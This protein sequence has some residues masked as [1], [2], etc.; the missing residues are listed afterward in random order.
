MEVYE[1]TIGYQCSRKP[2]MTITAVEKL[3][4]FCFV[5]LTMSFAHDYTEPIHS[6][7]SNPIGDEDFGFCL[8]S[9]LKTKYARQHKHFS[10]LLLQIPLTGFCKISTR[11]LLAY[12]SAII[13]HK[14]TFV[15]KEI[16]ADNS[17]LYLR[18]QVPFLHL[19]RQF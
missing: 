19:V 10:S 6:P 9:L 17:K 8:W 7:L 18:E 4:A 11:A 16:L 3:T 14:L 1:N 13:C 2:F 12:Y 15:L 5:M